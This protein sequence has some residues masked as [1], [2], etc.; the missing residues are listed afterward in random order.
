MGVAKRGLR[1]EHL[2]RGL[3]LADRLTQLFEQH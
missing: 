2:V 1:A 3:G